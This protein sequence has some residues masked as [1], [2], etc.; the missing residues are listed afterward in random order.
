MVKVT[1]AQAGE[2]EFGIDISRVVEILKVQRVYPLPHLPASLTGVINTRGYVIPILDLRRR[3]GIEP[4]PGK[5]RIIIIRYGNEKVGLL[6]D[7]VKE[8]VSFESGEIIPPPSIFKGMKTE[9]LT[10]IGK[11]NDRIIILLNLD[12]LLS[13]E[14]KIQIEEATKIIGANDAETRTPS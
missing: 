2:D 14:E 9:Y 1:V 5:E 11:K 8:I 12:T 3:F 6:V 10:G 4:A 7:G 13:S